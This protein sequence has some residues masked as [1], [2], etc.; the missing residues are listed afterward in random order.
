MSLEDIEDYYRNTKK[1]IKEEEKIE[2][3]ATV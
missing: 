2:N 3:K 1:E